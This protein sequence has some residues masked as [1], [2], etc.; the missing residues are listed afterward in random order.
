MF[1]KQQFREFRLAQR[2]GVNLR[3]LENMDANQMRE[4]RLAA[5]SKLDLSYFTPN[6]PAEKMNVIRNLLEIKA[7]IDPGFIGSFN[8]EQLRQIKLGLDFGLDVKQYQFPYLT[9]AQMRVLRIRLL[10]TKV[11]NY[12][13]E[14]GLSSIFSIVSFKSYNDPNLMRYTEKVI[15][16][17]ERKND[18]EKQGDHNIG[19]Y[20][21]NQF[22]PAVNEVHMDDV[23]LDDH[24]DAPEESKVKA[25]HTLLARNTAFLNCALVSVSEKDFRVIKDYED[26]KKIDDYPAKN[27][28]KYDNAVSAAKDFQ[29][30]IMELEKDEVQFKLITRDLN[31]K[32]KVVLDLHE[33]I[34]RANDVKP[35]IQDFMISM[36]KDQGNEIRQPLLKKIADTS[37]SLAVK[38]AAQ[39]EIKEAKAIDQKS[40]AAPTTPQKEQA[41]DKEKQRI[42]K[43]IE[44]AQAITTS[45]TKLSSIAEKNNDPH[46][47][48][49]VLQNPNCSTTLVNKYL[50][51]ENV[52]IQN[53]AKAVL[54]H[55]SQMKSIQAH[56]SVRQIVKEI[57]SHFLTKDKKPIMLSI[58]RLPDTNKFGINATCVI[59]SSSIQ[60]QNDQATVR[61]NPERT[62]EILLGKESK[63]IISGKELQQQLEHKHDRS[64]DERLDDA[65]N[66]L[67]NQQEV[68]EKAPEKQQ[69]VDQGV[70]R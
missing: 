28:V 59:P 58:I 5:Q 16:H 21:K 43:L 3:L 8:A 2:N 19:D 20:V 23:K 12:I 24:L 52:D 13:K 45:S 14:N 64:L 54:Q 29:S 49:A 32:E 63:G 4:T 6:V 55:R 15:D 18:P 70:E 25:D 38:K 40:K 56:I 34:N 57:P 17:I 22:A 51:H 61:L 66:K 41:V 36:L 60:K 53:T 1:N 68:N 47:L 27:V 42:E 7:E 50:D 46:V 26:N 65:R 37:N 67:A 11:I 48:Q 9:A 10:A 62:F 35:E 69:E 44:K 33:E 31:I 39:E 30:I